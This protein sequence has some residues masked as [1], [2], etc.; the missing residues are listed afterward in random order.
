M[1]A[2][3]FGNLYLSSIQQGIQAL[4]AT[5]DMFI[6]YRHQDDFNSQLFEWAGDHK[7]TIMLNAGYSSEIRNLEDF[8]SSPGNIFPFCSFYEEEDALD[9]A[10]TTIGIILPE[11]IYKLSA[12]LRSGIVTDSEILYIKKP[13]TQLGRPDSLS[14][15]RFNSLWSTSFNDHNS[16]YDILTAE[17][18]SDFERELV[19]RLN[20]YSLAS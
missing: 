16:L 12:M 3:F 9:G 14:T 2:Y 7:T 18:F 5:T 19:I 10:L 17:E 8:F 11:R 6:K 20:R 15:E 4:H 1:R 13:T